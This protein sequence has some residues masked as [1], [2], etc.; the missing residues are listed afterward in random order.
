M[1]YLP[2]LGQLGIGTI[3][4]I[5]ATA[6]EVVGYANAAVREFIIASAGTAIDM[7]DS[8]F[9]GP[10]KSLIDNFNMLKLYVA[11]IFPHIQL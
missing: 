7:K 6:L 11:S 4:R 5:G 8:T 2:G 10:I 9:L 1:K 3:D